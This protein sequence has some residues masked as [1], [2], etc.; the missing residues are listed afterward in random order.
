MII[1]QSDIA[2]IFISFFPS[3]FLSL[4]TCHT[5][6]IERRVSSLSPWARLHIR[7]L[8]LSFARS[9]CFLCRL[10]LL[11]LFSW[12]LPLLNYTSRFLLCHL[13]VCLFFFYFLHSPCLLSFCH[14]LLVP[15]FDLN[16]LYPLAFPTSLF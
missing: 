9:L 11:L 5:K 13:F 15:P 14:S 12:H 4:L 10:W 6:Q 8:F 2:S 1:P 16:Y 7:L 3:L